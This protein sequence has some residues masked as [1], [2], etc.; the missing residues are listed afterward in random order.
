MSFMSKIM[1]PSPKNVSFGESF[2]KDLI[3]PSK[4]GVNVTATTALQI[5][6][7]FAC[8]RVLAEGVAQVPLKLFK[9]NDDGGGTPAKDNS[10][11][12]ILHRKPNAW[13]TSFE[14]RENLIFQA[15]LIGNFYAFKNRLSAPRSKL[16]EIIPFEPGACVPHR[17]IKGDGFYT[18]TAT[19]GEEKDFLPEDIW[20]VRGPSWD[21]WR[22]L[23]AVKLAREAFGLAIA[24]ENAHAKL[25]ANGAQLSGLYSVDGTLGTEQHDNMSE[26][27]KKKTTGANR[28][29]PFVLDHGAKWTQI[30]MSGVDSQHLETRKFQIEE[31]CRPFRIMPIMIGQADKAATYASA[32]QMF[33]AHVIHTL[34]PWY[35]RLEQSMDVNLLTDAELKQGYYTKFIPNALMRGTAS[36]RADYYWKMWQMAGLNSNEIRAMEEMNSYP[37]GEKFFAPANMMIADEAQAAQAMDSLAIWF[38]NRKDKEHAKTDN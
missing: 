11:Y 20:H 26:W 15:G 28:F 4:S 21:T 34:M 22:G 24:T 7:V 29:T 10:L 38:K 32:E 12:N 2:W 36:S 37:G 8:L 23:A 27:I 16:M 35:E 5:T 13:Q 31:I 25:H 17:T 33:L 6:A 3:H 19:D 18:V 14:F 30:A 9:A 1:R